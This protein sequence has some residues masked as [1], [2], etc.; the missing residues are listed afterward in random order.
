MHA[1]VRYFCHLASAQDEALISRIAANLARPEE[2]SIVAAHLSAE[3]DALALA[4]ALAGSA[5]AMRRRCAWPLE[6]KR[7]QARRFLAW[8]SAHGVETIGFQA[9]RAMC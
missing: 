6:L 5:A 9:H 8:C 7:A 1:V 4:P 2:A 3:D